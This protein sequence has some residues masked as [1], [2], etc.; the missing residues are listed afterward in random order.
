[1]KLQKHMTMGSPKM[2]HGP[3]LGFPMTPDGSFESPEQRMERERAEIALDCRVPVDAVKRTPQGTWEVLGFSPEAFKQVYEK[4]G[5][6]G[7]N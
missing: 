4:D 1:M 6:Y 3:E 7:K 5:E 2:N